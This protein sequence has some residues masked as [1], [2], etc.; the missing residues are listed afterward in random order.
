M[1]GVDVVLHRPSAADL[2]QRQAARAATPRPGN[3]TPEQAQRIGVQFEQMFLSQML[4]PMFEGLG[5]D[6]LFGGGSGERMFR[7]FQI[8]TYAQA[9]SRRG[10]VGI[11]ERVAREILSL[12]EKNNG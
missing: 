10:G 11:A 7:S 12:Q 3:A 6:G 1:T 2:V 5:T 4:A 8:D 9:I